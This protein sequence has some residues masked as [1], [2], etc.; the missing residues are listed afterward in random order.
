MPN[1]LILKTESANI[2]WAIQSKQKKLKLKTFSIDEKNYK[3]LVIYFIRYVHRKSIKMLSL[4]FLELT[5]KIE[6]HWR[7]NTDGWWLYAR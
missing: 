1:K 2:N 5:G 6:E 4:Y 7:K 3:N